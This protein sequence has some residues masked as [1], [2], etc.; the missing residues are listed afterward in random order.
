MGEFAF[1]VG[2]CRPPFELLLLGQMG[3]QQAETLRVC[4]Q[5][6]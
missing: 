6:I 2:P 5:G 1:Q 3:G 4:S